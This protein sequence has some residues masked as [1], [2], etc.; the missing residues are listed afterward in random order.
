MGFW[1]QLLALGSGLTRRLEESAHH[2]GKSIDHDAIVIWVEP[3][4]AGREP[5]LLLLDRHLWVTENPDTRSQWR[6][7]CQRRQIGPDWDGNGDYL[8]NVG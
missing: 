4:L 2:A 5:V 6:F 7:T 1:G 8:G 3:R